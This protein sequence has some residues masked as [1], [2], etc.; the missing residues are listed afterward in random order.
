MHPVPDGVM[1]HYETVLKMHEIPLNLFANYRKWLRYS[2]DFRFKYLNSC[3]H[4]EQVRLFLGKLRKKKRS[5]AQCQQAA[6][7][8]SLF[9]EIHGLETTTGDPVELPDRRNSDKPLSVDI[10]LPIVNEQKSLYCVAGYQVKSDSPEWYEVL[11]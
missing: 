11:G 4:S 7:A 3:E 8:A 2:L 10:S 9:F 1:C 6:H 5:E